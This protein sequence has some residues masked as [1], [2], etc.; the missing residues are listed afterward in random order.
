MKKQ[1]Y[2]EVNIGSRWW[3]RYV[4]QSAQI[5]GK[6]WI[7]PFSYSMGYWEY[8]VTTNFDGRLVVKES[9]IFESADK[10]AVTDRGVG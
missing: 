4:W 5:I 2:V 9:E 8:L 1:Y 6:R 3:P 7:E 10:K